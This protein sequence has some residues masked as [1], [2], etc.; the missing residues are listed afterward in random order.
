M[1][2]ESYKYRDFIIENKSDFDKKSLND[3]KE[4][5]DLPVQ[6]QK[7]KERDEIAICY[8]DGEK[9]FVNESKKLRCERNKRKYEKKDLG[10]ES[11]KEIDRKFY[12]SKGPLMIRKKK[13]TFGR[14]PLK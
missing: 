5:F 13:H 6:S 2:N 1:E 9:D 4:Q 7:F 8:T 12:N 11:K 3:Y 10:E 14:Y